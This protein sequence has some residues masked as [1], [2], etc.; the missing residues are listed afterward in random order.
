VVLA[1]AIA[2]PAQD[3]Q[4]S[5]DAAK[6]KTL[7]NFNGTNGGP[8]HSLHPVQGTDG[9]LYGTTFSGGANSAGTLFKMTPAGALTTIFS[10]CVIKPGCNDGSGPSDVG[11]LALGTDRNFYGSTQSGGPTG[12]GTVFK[13]IPGGTQE[14]LSGLCFQPNCT[15]GGIDYTGLVRGADGNFYGTTSAG[16]ANDNSLCPGD[17]VS[18]GC[19]TVFKITPSV[20]VT[21]TVI[22][23]FCSQTNCPDGDFPETALLSAA[24]GNLY[25]MTGA[26]GANGFGTIYKI[27]LGGK[28]TVLHNFASTEN[29][30]SN[31]CAP[32]IQ[33]TN[34]NFYGTA[35]GAGASRNG[36]VFKMTPAGAFTTIYN[37]CSQTNCADGANPN[38]LMQATDGNLYGAAWD[39]GSGSGTLFRITP[40]GALKTL[41]T[42]DG[43]DGTA[44]EGLAQATDGTLYGTTAFGGTG[45][46]PGPGGCGT[47]FSLSVGLRPFVE[48]LPT[49]GKAGATIQ[50][51]GYDLTDATSVSFN[52]TPAVF[53]VDSKTLISAT[54]PTG[55]TTG[56][57]TVAGPTAALKSNVKFQVRP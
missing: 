21:F 30:C 50:I 33:A 57:V 15:D 18:P 44:P 37:F 3:E 35:F 55:A 16:G 17:G 25:G 9:N 52:G 56:F 32:L 29:G 27:T 47:V 48:T 19:G 43:T 20:P 41:H 5:P 42:F 11:A 40:E 45:N 38:A 14:I 8:F 54:V 22:Y 49:A 31:W 13:T 1:A 12:H 6:F 4:T 24:D 28:L 53:T 26:G 46:C 34:G 39:G 23:S 2:S 10:F 51:L 7:V 36:I